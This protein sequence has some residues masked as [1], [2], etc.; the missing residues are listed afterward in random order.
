MSYE[1]IKRRLWH[2]DKILILYI[3]LVGNL[4]A[5]MAGEGTILLYIIGGL[6]YVAIANHDDS[7]YKQDE[8]K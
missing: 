3:A 1:F 7:L 6:L 5:Q 8:S 4:L 2:N